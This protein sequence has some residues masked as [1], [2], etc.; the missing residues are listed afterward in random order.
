MNETLKTWNLYRLGTKLVVTVQEA[1]DG[2]YLWDAGSAWGWGS[3]YSTP[4]A[5]ADAWSETYGHQW[6]QLVLKQ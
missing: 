5:A 4:K 3:G 2:T 6:D 1:D